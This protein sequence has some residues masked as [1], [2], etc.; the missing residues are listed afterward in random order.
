MTRVVENIIASQAHCW[1]PLAGHAGLV[2]ALTSSAELARTYPTRLPLVSLQTLSRPVLQTCIVSKPIE[3]GPG[4][5][6]TYIPCDWDVMRY[7]YLGRPVRISVKSV[8]CG[9][10]L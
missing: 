3:L 2:T 9:I 7:Y 1:V 8:P 6:G 10:A 4:Q 5:R